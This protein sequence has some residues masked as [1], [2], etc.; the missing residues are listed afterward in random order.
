MTSLDRRRWERASRHLDHILDLPPDE[1][2]AYAAR[3]RLEDAESGADLDALLAEHRAILAEGFLDAAPSLRDAPAPPQPLPLAGVTLGAYTLMAPIGYG[4]MGSVWLAQ[5]SDGRFEGRA[6]LKLLNAALVGQAGEQRFKREGTIL[7]R[8]THPHIARLIDA[9]VTGSGQP[10]LVLEHVQGRHIDRYCDERHLGVRERIQLFLD[11]QAAVAHAHANLIV[12]RD[13]KPSN[14]L[15]TDDGHV[16]LLDFGIAKLLEDDDAELAATVL[17]REGAHL[18]TPRYAAPEQVNGGRITTATDV[19]A[20]GVLFF[21]LLTGRHPTAHHAKSAAEFVRAIADNEPTRLSTTLDADNVDD[22]AAIAERRS[23][24]PER[25]RR[26]LRGDLDTI[27]A[28]ALKRAPEDRYASV[29]EFAADLQRYLDDQPIAARRDSLGYRAAKFVLRHRRGVTAAAATVAL[30]IGLVGF[31]TVQLTRERDRARVEADKATRMSELLTGLFRGA[32]PYRT[33][34]AKEPT[35]R[36]LLDFGAERVDR[37]LGDRPELQAEMFALIGRTY[38]RMGLPQE[39]TPLLQRALAIGRRAL[40]P[41]HVQIAQS[42]NNLGVLL[43]EQGD[44]A[45]AEPLLAEGLAMRKR[46]L[47]P[48]HADVAITLVEY[49]RVLQDQGR[50]DEAEPYLRESLAVRRQVFGEE[51]RETAVSKS[52]LGRSLL[53]RGDLAGA[54]P[55]LRENLATTERQLGPDHPTPASARGNLAVW[56]LAAG[57]VSGAEAMFREALD[58]HRRVMGPDH[59]VSLRSLASIGLALEL[60]GRFDE[61]L[62][63]YDE[64]LRLGTARL[65]A[66]HPDV[67]GFALGA[68][69]VRLARG[70]AREVEATLREVLHERQRLYPAYEHRVAQAHS[71]LGWALLQLGRVDEAET[72]MLDADRGFRAIAGLEGRERE[73]NRARL[74][75]L[76]RDTGRDA[77]AGRLR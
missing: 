44:L 71:A 35:V 2:D 52:G 73:A 17:T 18:L 53:R 76:Y 38:E 74:A 77:D 36:N 27:L 66:R 41:E 6:A 4:G 42:L 67:L 23:T 50:H 59:P 58:V 55:L 12:H 70:E 39:A 1:R 63:A 37:E 22:T 61:A 75:A 9:G 60:Q 47:G 20:L 30:I 33:P 56:K 64:S 31:Y 32:D 62:A 26:L 21:E 15:V 68:A 7:A 45:G 54:E 8:L 5:R 49:A 51:H 40:G 69:R 43:R 16:K 14:V 48:V 28:K 3:L 29:A 65:G 46:L 24:T 10:Y 57:D 34:D 72:E 25:L 13:L 19:Y 11:V